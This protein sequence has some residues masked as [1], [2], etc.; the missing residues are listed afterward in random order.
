MGCAMPEFEQGMN[1][2]R[3]GVLLAGLPASVA[4]MTINRFCSS[5]LNAVSI[6][7]DRIRTGEADIMI[8]AGTESMSMIP[9]L[10]RLAL[11]EAVFAH[12][13]E[14]RH[15]L[16]HGAHRGEGGRA[17]EDLA[18]GAG[19]VRAGVAPARARRAGGRRVR[20]R[21]QRRSRSH[22]DL[23]DLATERIVARVKDDRAATKGRVRTRRPD[24][25]G[26]AAAGVRREGLGHGGQQLADVRRRGRVDPRVRARA[27]RARRSSARTLGGLCGGRRAARDH[28]H[29]PHRGDS[30]G[31]RHDRH[32]H[33]RTST[34]S[35]STRRSPRR[36]WP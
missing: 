32:S 22:E 13:R 33:G 1:V 17:V 26:E 3:I 5:G 14:R 8:A 21:D 23:P 10:G 18:R 28:G 16:R 6:A 20:A 36:P 2:A 15:R 27:A 25:P 19:R 9:M 30:E 4:G 11:N 35:S 7:A 34:G 31:P 29:R 24:G 12:G